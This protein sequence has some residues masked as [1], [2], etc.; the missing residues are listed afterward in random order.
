MNHID[1]NKPASLKLDSYSNQLYFVIS[2]VIRHIIIIIYSKMELKDI[3][4]GDV[5][6]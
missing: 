2:F 3:T 5:K 4:S 6:K 1:L